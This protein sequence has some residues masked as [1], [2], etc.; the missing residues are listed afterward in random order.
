MI[1]NDKNPSL[2]LVLINVTFLWLSQ[3]CKCHQN[4]PTQ[5]CIRP[6]GY[7]TWISAC[8]VRNHRIPGLYH[9]PLVFLTHGTT[10]WKLLRNHPN[11]WTILDQPIPYPGLL[12]TPW[13]SWI[14]PWPATGMH[15]AD[16][17][18]LK[19][20]LRSACFPVRR[21]RMGCDPSWR[22]W[23]IQKRNES[24]RIWWIDHSYWKLERDLC[25]RCLLSLDRS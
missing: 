11:P 12:G 8:F 10:D 18:A 17:H 14:N 21:L 16:H 5:G 20:R 15:S 6:V 13:F 7:Q 23:K 25:Q 24:D 9:Q 1:R 3:L 4:I 2:S 22:R 19:A